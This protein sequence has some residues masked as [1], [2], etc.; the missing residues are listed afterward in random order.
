MPTDLSQFEEIWCWDFEFVPAPGELYD[1]VCLGAVELRSGREIALWRDELGEQPPFRTD[2]K[3]LFVA[4]VANAEVACHLALGWP[5]PANV[6]DLSPV[7][8]NLT[9]GRATPEGKGLIG[10]QRYFGIDPIDSKRK[11]AMQKRIMQGWPFTPEERAE[12][13]RYVLGDAK[14]LV[15]LLERVLPELDLGVALHWGEFAAVSA[16]MQHHGVPINGEIFRQL[17][18]EKVWREI[19]D[20]MVPTIDAQYGVYTRNAAGDWTFSM[21]KWTAYLKREG[22]YELWPRLASGALD[23][24]RKTFENMSKGFPPLEAL[25]QL[26]HARDKMRK[27]KLAVGAD[28]HNRVVLW[29]FKSKTG[30]TQPKAA[31][32]IFSPAVWIGSSRPLKQHSRHKPSSASGCCTWPGKPRA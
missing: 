9:N 30:R 3:V 18:D 29:P 20:D 19:R 32:W 10:M 13:L 6:L 25:R 28:N 27:V 4:F 23:M 11:E 7:F 22:L 16:L 31:E 2:E 12:A 24:R 26:R 8:R 17:A 1:V 21:E 15:Q 14:A 5:V